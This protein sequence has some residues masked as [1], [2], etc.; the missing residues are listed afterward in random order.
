MLAGFRAWTLKARARVEGSSG[1]L[2]SSPQ[3]ISSVAFVNA[4]DVSLT[5]PGSQA[6][7][8]NLVC[9]FTL[10]SRQETGAPS[11]SLTL[12]RATGLDFSRLGLRPAPQRTGRFR[13]RQGFVKP[14]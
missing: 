4:Y 2:Q 11:L 14:G 9:P 13:R 3:H 10:M 1:N 12:V 7:K 8:S 6:G 5:S